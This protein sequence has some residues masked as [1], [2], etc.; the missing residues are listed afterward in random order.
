MFRLFLSVLLS[1]FIVPA[2]AAPGDERFLAAREAVRVGDRAKLNLLAPGLRDHPLGVYAEYWQLLQCLQDKNND[3]CEQP[4]RDFLIRHDGEYIGE[5]LRADWLSTQGRKG[6]LTA[7]ATEYPKLRQPD[8]ALRCYALQD[9]R[10]RGD[11][12]AEDEALSL[13]FS[14]MD[15]PEACTPVIE[16]LVQDKK[17]FTDEVWRRLRLQFE[18]NK[19]AAARVT[20]NYLPAAQTPDVHVFNNVIDKSAAYL[21]K[22]PAGWE[23][24]RQGKELAALAVQRMARNDPYAAANMLE[25]LQAKLEPE[26]RA[27]AWSQIA[28]QGA[29]RHQS[30]ALRWYRNAA[31]ANP[32]V[33]MSDNVTEWKIRAA[34]RAGDWE[35]VRATIMQLPP[36]LADKPDW[37]YWQGRALQVQGKGAEAAAL[38]ARI[39][40]QPNFY[41]NLADNELGRAIEIPPRAAPPTQEELAR[42]GRIPGI[43]RG[44]AFFSLDLR[45]EGVREWNWAVR[46]MND[47]ELLAAAQ[48]ARE[49]NVYD[50]AIS[51]AERT[52][53]EHDYSLRYLAPFLEQMVPAARAQELDNAWVYG[54][55]RQESRFVTQARS[56]AGASGLM[57]LMPKTA[58][59]VAKKIGI[60]DYH[61]SKV[62]DVDINLL[63]GTSYLRMV[64]ESLD[65]HPLLASAAYN[66]GPGRARKWRASQP[67][68]GAI[69]AETIPFDET[70][71]YVKKVMS[72]TIYYAARF[73]GRPESL[74]ERLGTVG[75]AGPPPAA[76]ENL[77]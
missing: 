72:N 25:S 8:Q 20:V 24:T 39:A 2:I 36:R 10:N 43:A 3:S 28:W 17:V 73:N 48:L 42:A 11:K 52:N 6:D 30:D 62:N 12:S 77:P 16:G 60:K 67:L 33:S 29:L 9:R 63:L 65:N 19:V 21:A 35:T 74:K 13:W 71:D 57:Q 56:S 14:L 37:I 22:R 15:P 50:R 26:E 18:A 55:I 44:L 61:Q 75:V 68:E 51:T 40:G 32:S 64:L 59:W 49:N 23:K 41:G 1:V 69:Y 7:F 38:F 53:I 58:Q 31:T 70:R 54:L 5:R 4:L 66:A 46:E 27:W 76:S 34:L 45:L 47:R